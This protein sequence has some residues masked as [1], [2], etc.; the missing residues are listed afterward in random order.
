MNLIDTVKLKSNYEIAFSDP[1][2]NWDIYINAKGE[3]LSIAK[4][5]G[6]ISTF[7]GDTNYIKRLIASNYFSELEYIT[8]HGRKCFA[9]LYSELRQDSR[10]RKFGVLRWN[11]N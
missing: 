4:K 8:D 7:Y 1:S 3:A 11:R 9:G 10:G 6:C 5:K 2:S